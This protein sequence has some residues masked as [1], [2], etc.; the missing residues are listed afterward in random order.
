MSH[1]HTS[2]RPAAQVQAA[3]M[4]PA[5]LKGSPARIALARIAP[6]RI[7]LATIALATI[8]LPLAAQMQPAQ[9]QESFPRFNADVAIELQNDSVVSSEDADAEINDL[10]PT[11][12]PYLRFQATEG[13]SL[14]ASLVIEPVL[15]PEPGNSRFFGD[16]GMFV[17]ELKIVYEAGELTLQ[18]G[19]FNPSF[20]LAWDLAPGIYG[21][22]FAGDYELTERLGG[23]A[24]YTF[25]GRHDSGHTF[26]F[27]LFRLDTSPLS[28]S[29][30]TDRGETNR[31][32]GG[33][34]N[35][36]APTSISATLDGQGF[37][38]GWDYH[39]G[40]TRQDVENGED[41]VGVVGAAYS[42]LD[43]NDRLTFDPLLE[44][45]YLSSDDGA[46]QD[47]LYVTGSAGFG[48]DAFNVALSYTYR[49]TDPAS[50]D[51]SVVDGLFQA[52]G[53]YDFGNGL[54]FDLGYK[55]DDSEGT[56][57]HTIGALLAYEFS[58]G[59]P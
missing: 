31:S 37:G 32:D 13:L 25:G 47:R 10:A 53:G 54:T 40:V 7:A 48:Y 51:P 56:E 20:G 38:G 55:F 19:K 52:S 36:G 46:G 42:S 26:Q 1:N 27:N 44:V 15:D 2:R 35:T 59:F 5:P 29:V 30:F 18:G 58:I 28:E 3:R 23:S 45:A 6:A 49:E 43:L 50:G 34:S 12:E 17:E 24:A 33:P 4:A 9:A 11:V 8:G 14:D 57:S 21:T 16:V 22:D 39:L 41:F